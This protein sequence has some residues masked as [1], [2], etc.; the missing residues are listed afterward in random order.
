VL[1]DLNKA[2]RKLADK[3]EGPPKQIAKKIDT[4]L[5]VLAAGGRKFVESY[6]DLLGKG[7]A[8]LPVGAVAGFLASAGLPKEL[9]DTIWS[10]L[11]GSRQ[12]LLRGHRP[13]WQIFRPR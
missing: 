4:T 9:V 7:A 2:L 5:G 10:Q 8:A 6:A 1:R 12:S 11:K 13:T 3:D